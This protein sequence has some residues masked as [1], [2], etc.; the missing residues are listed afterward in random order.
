MR[1][2]FEAIALHVH[3]NGKYHSSQVEI[4]PSS[5]IPELGPTI[6][7][8]LSKIEKQREQKPRVAKWGVHLAIHCVDTWT[9]PSPMPDTRASEE[10][11]GGG[12]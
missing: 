10:S 3:D 4:T 9:H 2:D 11:R 8:V 12:K 7:N 5:P 6:V 1:G